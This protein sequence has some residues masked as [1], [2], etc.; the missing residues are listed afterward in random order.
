M[1]AVET[2]TGVPR[3]AVRTLRRAAT[4]NYRVTICTVLLA[5]ATL[6]AVFAPLL[7]PY[8]PN[9]LA[10]GDPLS[11]PSPD[12]IFGVDNFGRDQLSRILDGARISLGISAVV[13]VVSMGVGAPLGLILGYRRG[14]VDFVV[15]RFLDLL[16]A[17]PGILIA[18]V[19]ATALGPGLT[20]AAIAMCVIYVPQATRFVRGVVASESVKD[21]VVAARTVGASGFRVIFVHIL[22]NIR[23]QLLVITTLVMSF[24]VLTEAALSF[25]GVGAQAPSSSWG[26]MLTDGRDFLMTQPFLAV[27]PAL[28]I[29]ALVLI[30]NGLG[31]GLRDRLDADAV[32]VDQKAA[33]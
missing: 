14:R 19:L 29:A 31:D 28:A 24:A 30:L 1:T 15:S 12:H 33:P 8:G 5:L 6:A 22:P 11:P 21:Y 23:S 4:R 32:T 7:A 13:T 9:D 25:L 16:F 3:A 2:A 26:R 17:F 10:V 20:T 27:V 18:L